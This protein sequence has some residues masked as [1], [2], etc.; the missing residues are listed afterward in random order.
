VW[1]SLESFRHAADLLG[2]PRPRRAAP[3]PLWKALELATAATEPIVPNA[4]L[5]PQTV[6]MLGA[7]FRFR[8]VR[9]RRE[10]GWNPRPFADVLRDTIQ[11]AGL[12]LRD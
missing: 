2:V 6:R 4:L 10:L 1:T 9:A 3:R 11:R 8:S 5:T 7:H 12:R